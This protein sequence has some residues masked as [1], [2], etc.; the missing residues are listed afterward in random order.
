[1]EQP[2]SNPHKKGKSKLIS[3]LMLEGWSNDKIYNHITDNIL[4]AR[5]TNPITIEMIYHVRTR[6]NQKGITAKMKELKEQQEQTVVT[7]EKELRE[8]PEDDGSPRI[9]YDSQLQ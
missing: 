1:M 3:E 5:F 6:F 7:P 4:D 2:I 8:T 9:L